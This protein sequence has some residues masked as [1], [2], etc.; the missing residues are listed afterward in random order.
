[1]N[2]QVNYIM[3][4]FILALLIPFGVFVIDKAILTERT[5]EASSIVI[6]HGIKPGEIVLSQAAAKG[7]TLFMQ[8]CASCHHLFKD[9]TGPSLV[10]IEKRG[11]WAD[12]KNVYAWTRNPAA[13]MATNSYTQ[14]LKKVYAV[15]MPAFPDMSE[16]EIDNVMTYINYVGEGMGY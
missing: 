2:H 4:G 13:F 6:D 8:K 7:K 15:I 9:Q 10:G 11:P 14:D 3:Q 1:M 12:R 5:S 16:E